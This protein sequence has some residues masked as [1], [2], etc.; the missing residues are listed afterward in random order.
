MAAAPVRGVAAGT[1]RRDRRG[2]RQLEGEVG[3]DMSAVACLIG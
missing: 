3:S 2:V 1:G